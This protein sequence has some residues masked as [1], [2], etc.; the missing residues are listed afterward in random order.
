VKRYHPA[1]S[2]HATAPPWFSSGAAADRFVISFPLLLAVP[3]L[4]PA[5]VTR[6]MKLLLLTL[7]VSV[8]FAAWQWFRPYEWKPDPGA[9][10]TV[11]QTLVERDHSNLWLRVFLKQSGGESHDFMKPVR[12]LAAGGSEHEPADTAMSGNPARQMEEL[13]FSFWLAEKDFGGPL[14]LQINDGT[15]LIR[16]GDSLPKVGDGAFRAFNSTRW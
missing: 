6:R 9:R 7:G 15:L 10:Y 13:V 14:K 3:S 11:Q 2:N 12:L 5:A 8:I 1:G 16:T 4:Q